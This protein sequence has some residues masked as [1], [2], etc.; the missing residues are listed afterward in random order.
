MFIGKKATPNQGEVFV[1]I[2]KSIILETADWRENVAQKR[3]PNDRRNSAAAGILFALAN[4]P[5]PELPAETV[6]KLAECRNSLTRLTMDAARTVG[7]RVRPIG[8][9]EFISLIL[10]LAADEAAEIERVFSGV[11]AGR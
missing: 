8:L 10:A 2:I 6:A 4:G 3:Y 11:E 1:A 5:S 9:A 7:F